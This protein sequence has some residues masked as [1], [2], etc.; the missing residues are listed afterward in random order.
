MK[1]QHWAKK[2]ADKIK[3]EIEKT[4]VSYITTDNIKGLRLYLSV[5]YFV[6]K[7]GELTYKITRS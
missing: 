1:K 7:T 6:F 2:D 4:G 3:R 5:E